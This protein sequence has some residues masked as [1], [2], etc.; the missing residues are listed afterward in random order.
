MT[1][2]VLYSPQTVEFTEEEDAQE[3]F[4]RLLHAGVFV[5]VCAACNSE[6]HDTSL[7]I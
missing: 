1:E 6:F 7:L 2:E 5:E 3:K 4:I